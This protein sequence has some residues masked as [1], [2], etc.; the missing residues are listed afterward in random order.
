MGWRSAPLGLLRTIAFASLAAVAALALAGAVGPARAIAAEPPIVPH[1]G[2]TYPLGTRVT[3]PCDPAGD[4]DGGLQSA[5]DYEGYRDDQGRWHYSDYR[6]LHNDWANSGSPSD[7]WE[8]RAVRLRDAAGRL[9]PKCAPLTLRHPGRY[10][11]CVVVPSD[12]EVLCASTVH[13]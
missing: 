11:L 8:I 1:K 4:P 7:G 13:F 9:L 2:E 10:E 6:D 5:I 12:P 3:G